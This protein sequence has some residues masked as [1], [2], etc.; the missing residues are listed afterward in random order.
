MISKHNVGHDVRQTGRTFGQNC[1]SFS[2]RP[3]YPAPAEESVC[4]RAPRRSRDLVA[5]A[6]TC[7]QNVIDNE[8]SAK[9]RC[10]RSALPASLARARPFPLSLLLWRSAPFAEDGRSS[11]TTLHTCTRVRPRE[12]EDW[13]RCDALPEN[14][15]RGIR[16]VPRHRQLSPGEGVDVSRQ[17]P[18]DPQWM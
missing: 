7:A 12:A 14:P 10:S 16:E 3:I 11:C 17:M 1:R 13:L 9:Q 6:C 4:G 8:A 18:S 15:F 2:I 5:A